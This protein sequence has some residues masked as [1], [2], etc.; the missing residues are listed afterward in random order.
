MI[1][2]RVEGHGREREQE[3]NESGSLETRVHSIQFNDLQK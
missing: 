3:R 2:S 1:A